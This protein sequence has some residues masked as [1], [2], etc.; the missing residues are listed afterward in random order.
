MA[1]FWASKK[2]DCTWTFLV[3]LLTVAVTY[4]HEAV[5]SKLKTKIYSHLDMEEQSS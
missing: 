1:S 4:L 5:F 3:V 2:K